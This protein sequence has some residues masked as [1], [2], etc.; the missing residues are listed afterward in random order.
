MGGTVP[1]VDDGVV[2]LGACLWVPP[3]NRS[4]IGPRRAFRRLSG[5][6]LKEWKLR[7]RPHRCD[8]GWPDIWSR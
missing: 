8:C 6:G 3:W 2:H 7:G 5:P 1:P 4:R